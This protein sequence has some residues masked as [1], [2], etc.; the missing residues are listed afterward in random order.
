M[1]AIGPVRATDKENTKLDW[2][3]PRP[4]FEWRHSIW[5]FDFDAAASTKNSLLSW[6]FFGPGSP[7]LE[8]ANDPDAD[9]TKF[10]HAF[11]SNPEYGR[12]I[13]Q[14]FEA[15]HRQAKRGA[16]V[17]CLVPANTGTRWF[18]YCEEKASHIEVLTGRV[19]YWYDGKPMPP[20]ED[21]NTSDS[22]LVQWRK[23][24]EGA[25]ISVT[26][27]KKEMAKYE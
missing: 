20:K 2:E 5:K 27:W 9:W 14:F 19:G 7:H 3:T 25:T 23:G 21:R 6:S 4:L 12:V 17:E 1:S 8:D 15:Y 18:K 26:D 22:M 24:K 10:G 16:L 13:M 11:F